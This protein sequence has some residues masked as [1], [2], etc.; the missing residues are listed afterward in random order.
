M[1]GEARRCLVQPPGLQDS[2][3]SALQFYRQFHGAK[4]E[5]TY[6][7]AR[8]LKHVAPGPG[9]QCPPRPLGSPRPA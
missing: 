6:A 5:A 4:E 8:A 2:A 7:D 1:G 3:F 9:S